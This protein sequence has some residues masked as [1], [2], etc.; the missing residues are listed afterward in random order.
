MGVAFYIICLNV[1]TLFAIRTRGRIRP[2]CPDR[3]LCTGGAP[4]TTL[5]V[6]CLGH[7]DIDHQQLSDQLDLLLS[8][9]LTY[10]RLTS[11]TIINSSLTHVP[12]SVCRLTRLT[13]LNLQSNRLTRLP[14]NCLSNLTA[15]MSF[16][17]SRNNIS[18]I[19]D[20]LFEGLRKL[21][22]L[23][24][25][26]NRISSIGLRVF[27]NSAMLTSLRGVYL[28]YNIIASLEPWPYWFDTKRTPKGAY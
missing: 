7:T 25:S 24:F 6:D 10:G 28:Q 12:R 26:Y 27:N 22:Q 1:V 14:D 8:N 21:A 5:T 20:G 4:Y 19:Q 11:L 18:E 15:L 13:R 17:A 3:C 23:D 9:N 2:L 16:N